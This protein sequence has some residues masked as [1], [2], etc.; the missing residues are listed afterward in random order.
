[1]FDVEGCDQI[2]RLLEHFE[3]RFEDELSAGDDLN[4]ELNE[5]KKQ[6][7]PPAHL[8]RKH[9]KE[10]A[11]LISELIEAESEL[12]DAEDEFETARAE[13]IE[14]EAKEVKLQQTI[15]K[16]QALLE[17]IDS[18][19]DEASHIAAQL[20]SDNHLT[21]EQRNDLLHLYEQLLLELVSLY[22][23]RQ[24]L[25]DLDSLAAELKK[26]EEGLG[27]KVKKFEEYG[28]KV[29]GVESKIVGL[30]ESIGEM[31]S[32]IEEALD[33]LEDLDPK[34]EAKQKQYDKQMDKLVKMHKA[35]FAAWDK[36]KTHCD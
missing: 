19:E 20:D 4:K 31:E 25:G 17:Q 5:L 30:E 2:Q 16:V 7:I 32:P 18:L 33:L 27:E 35:L 23:M 12:I 14:Y 8:L 3:Q 36:W 28:P 9:G 15:L 29:G 11:D 34:K 21:D 6:M 13:M 1:M 22:D 24:Q 10:L 26:I